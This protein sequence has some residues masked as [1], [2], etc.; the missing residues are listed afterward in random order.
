MTAP[1]TQNTYLSNA[2]TRP[3]TTHVTVYSQSCG[4]SVSPKQP[5]PSGPVT[6]A[7]SGPSPTDKLSLL[8]SSLDLDLLCLDD[9]CLDDGAVRIRSTFSGFSGV[10]RPFLSR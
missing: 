7:F 8:S 9:A 6:R 10:R 4:M 3:V 1:T 5:G 2:M